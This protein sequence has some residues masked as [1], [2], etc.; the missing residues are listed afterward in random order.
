MRAYARAG[1][2]TSLVGACKGPEV[3]KSAGEIL[4][5]H[6]RVAVTRSQGHAQNIETRRTYDDSAIAGEHMTAELTL[7]F[8]TGSHTALKWRTY[9]YPWAKLVRRLMRDWATQ[10]TEA[11]WALLT[12]EQ[13]TA[14]KGS[15]G[16]WI[17]GRSLG[18]HRASDI[19]NRTALVLDVDNPP[20]DLMALVE[21]L[22]LECVVHQTHTPGR[23]RVVW[24]FSEAIEPELYPQLA[25]RAMGW[26]PGCDLVSDQVARVN[27]WPT[28]CSDTI[29][30][31]R[32]FEGPLLNPRKPPL[33]WPLDAGTERRLLLGS[34]AAE[35]VE[36][37]RRASKGE[38]NNTLNAAAW[39]L[40]RSDSLNSVV[41][42]QLVL[43]AMDAGMGPTEISR[44]IDS[45]RKAGVAAAVEDINRMFPDTP[46]TDEDASGRAQ[47]PKV[48][49]KSAPRFRVVSAASTTIEEP[50]ELWYG[51]LPLGSL[52][53]ISGMGG[54]G[55]STLDAWLAARASRGEMDGDVK[56]P[57]KTLMVMDEDDW[58]MDTVPRLMAA[59]ADLSMVFKLFLDKD[60]FETGVP[61][62]PEDI[63]L[64]HRVIRETGV[65]L[66]ILDVITSMMSA[67]MDPNNQA[68][69]RRL[70]N[71]LLQV[72]QQTGATIL[73]VNHWRKMSGNIS[74]M[75]SGSA[76][77]RDTARCVWAVVQDKD[78]R[79]YVKIDKYNRSE[80]AGQTFEFSLASKAIPGWKH[81]VGVI[82][83]W[84][85]SDIDAQD[86]LDGAS[87]E[88]RREDRELV[89]WLSAYLHSEG[90]ST[91]TDI[92]KAATTDGGWSAARVRKALE[93][94]QCV[95]M[96][97]P[98]DGPGRPAHVWALPG[99]AFSDDQ[100]SRVME[101]V[102]DEYRGLLG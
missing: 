8:C 7:D 67:G 6:A 62:F 81:T 75:I 66:V 31:P 10:E 13:Q 15:L 1:E 102:D 68:D 95:S 82:E 42:D 60:G 33:E 43:A 72:A 74:H 27:F 79:R 71:P 51:M 85:E 87:N 77:Y 98:A 2:Y 24:P 76:A 25:R 41:E 9:T 90:P 89:A 83:D 20:R 61:S 86:V 17:A 99:A 26:L 78:G 84:R 28:R 70:L 69:V 4:R 64:L 53:V 94:L 92:K 88:V 57:I 5:R 34:S 63:H 35:I 48:E 97:G 45:G 32:H 96:P 52:A 44:T 58:S 3:G 59:E 56:G 18:G 49:E 101:G 19:V 91:L 36:S 40:A 29:W 100:I 39:S 22:G 23:Y 54:I 50:R 93:A 21:G 65:Q 12:K 16:G 80:R 55:K 37:V 14:I 46:E 38:R 73:C 11:E 30:H 47:K